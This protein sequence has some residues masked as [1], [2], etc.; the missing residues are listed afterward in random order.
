MFH[1]YILYSSSRDKYYVGYSGDELQERLRKHNSKHK[2]F[3]GSTGDWSIVYSEL[4]I[5]KVSAINR[6]KEIKSRKSRKYIEH[7]AQRIPS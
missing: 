5:D 2:G 6:E 1:V 4:L 7:L 3:T